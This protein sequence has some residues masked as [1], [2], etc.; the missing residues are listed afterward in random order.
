MPELWKRIYLEAIKESSHNFNPVKENASPRETQFNARK[1][2]MR[3]HLFSF[4]DF[5]F[6]PFSKMDSTISICDWFISFLT[7]VG[8]TKERQRRRQM[9][10]GESVKCLPMSVINYYD[11][12]KNKTNYWSNVLYCSST[13]II[14]FELSCLLR[15]R[16]KIFE[17]NKK[18][19]LITAHSGE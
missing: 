6:F 2:T 5:S 9:S 11:E 7:N 4:W 16:N 14:N 17:M 3:D 1:K 8:E 12:W 19:F 18:T 13:N 15:K 10:A